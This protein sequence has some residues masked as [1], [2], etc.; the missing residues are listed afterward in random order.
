MI[1]HFFSENHYK[2]EFFKNKLITQDKELMKR[3]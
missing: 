2:E 1:K 3:T